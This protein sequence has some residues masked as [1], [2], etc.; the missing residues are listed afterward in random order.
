MSP[1]RVLVVDDHPLFR[2][3]VLF[4]LGR[5]PDIAVVGEGENGRQAVEMSQFLHPDVLLLDITMPESDGLQAAA[6]VRRVSPDTHIVILTASEEGDDLMAAMKVGAQGYVVKGA[7]AGEIVTAVLA[8]SRGEAYIT[9]KMAG[10]LLREMTQKPGNDPLAELTERE[11]QV[12]G[13]VARG[14]S[15]KEVGAELGLAE[16]TVKHYLT[17]VLQK[18]HVRSRVEAALL[19]QRHGIGQDPQNSSDPR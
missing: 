2:Q 15:N 12:L 18:L 1:I 3:G 8:A 14:L 17:S 10:N 9:P 6:A 16:K 5:N 13:L 11:R 19:A 7:G 4:T